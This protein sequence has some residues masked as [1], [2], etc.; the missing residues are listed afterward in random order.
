MFQISFNF[1]H[2]GDTFKFESECDLDDNYRLWQASLL[3]YVWKM[4]RRPLESES[5]IIRVTDHGKR[6][7]VKVN[8]D[9]FKRWSKLHFD[10]P[11]TEKKSDF[12]QLTTPDGEIVPD[13]SSILNLILKSIGDDDLSTYIQEKRAVYMDFHVILKPITREHIL[14]RRHWYSSYDLAFD[15][16][17]ADEEK[18]AMND[19]LL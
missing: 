9:L 14:K 6:R 16:Y 8:Q 2:G 12:I 4:S 3:H 17:G 1:E 19:V 7:K 18:E 15:D 11:D 10:F 13:N 5:D